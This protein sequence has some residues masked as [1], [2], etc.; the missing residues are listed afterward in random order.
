M[1]TIAFPA[2]RSQLSRGPTPFPPMPRPHAHAAGFPRILRA[3]LLP[4][5][6]ATDS[7]LC[8]QTHDRAASDL[9]QI[10]QPNGAELA[11]E[12]K[13]LA[14]ALLL[15]EAADAMISRVVNP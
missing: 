6:G 10:L 4:R 1:D 9:L 12:A 3:L 5:D 14:A 8:T 2:A 7:G 13:A 11:A 15:R